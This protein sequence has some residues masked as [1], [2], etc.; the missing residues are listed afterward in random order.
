MRKLH[1]LWGSLLVGLA[2]CTKSESDL[3]PMPVAAFTLSRSVIETGE[4]VQAT[5]TSQNAASYRWQANGMQDSV[6]TD[7]N[8]A[9]KAGRIPG[10]YNVKLTAFNTEE[11][12]VQAVVPVRIGRRTISALRLT[13]MPATRPNGQPWHAD[14]SGLNLSCAI[15]SGSVLGVRTATSGP[16]TNVQSTSLPLTW[17]LG[18][19]FFD[20]GMSVV[21]IDNVAGKQ[22][23]IA[24]IPINTTGPPANR[25]AQGK[26][27][28]EVQYNG[29][30][31]V[32][33]IETR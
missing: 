16:Y 13:A 25:D 9:F 7:T 15:Y 2:G 17:T 23:Y 5:N 30:A 8:P 19:E 20:G 28:Y 32:A 24:S 22:A 29:W 27:S 6:R 4:Q 10:T 26:G 18:G 14:G 12:R 1:Y 11:R 3:G 21:F 31:F 33:E